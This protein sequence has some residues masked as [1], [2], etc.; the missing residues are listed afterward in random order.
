MRILHAANVQACGAAGIEPLIALGRVTHHP[1]LG[2]RFAKALPTPDDPTP[3]EA[4]A[5]RLKTLEGRKLY[6]QRKHI[7]EPVFGIIKSVLGFRQFLLRGLDHVR[8]EW[9]LVTMAWNL[10]R[11]FVLSPAG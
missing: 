8:G 1:F 2:E 9:N 7:P 4:M 11:M 3:V 6:A 5:H 10:K